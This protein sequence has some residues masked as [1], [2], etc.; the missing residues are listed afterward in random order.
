MY[1][2][3]FLAEGAWELIKENK[4]KTQTYKPAKQTNHKTKPQRPK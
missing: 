4:Q 1:K 2:D 3:L